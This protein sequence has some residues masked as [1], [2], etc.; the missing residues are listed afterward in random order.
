[1]CG[2]GA[3]A[4]AERDCGWC[5]DVIG[6]SASR[7]RPKRRLADGLASGE[8]AGEF[9]ETF[10]FALASLSRRLERVLA[11][12]NLHTDC[13][14]AKLRELGWAVDGGW[15]SGFRV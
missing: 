6:L 7:C 13:A 5:C 9:G 4:G 11:V 10:E 3:L 8:L 1:M 14:S 2:H 15:S 12:C